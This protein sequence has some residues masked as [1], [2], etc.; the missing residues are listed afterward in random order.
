MI[1][2]VVGLSWVSQQDRPHDVFH[3]VTG[4]FQ[5]LAPCATR[6]SESDVA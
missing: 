2:D 6:C 3:V 4:L 5:V 1:F